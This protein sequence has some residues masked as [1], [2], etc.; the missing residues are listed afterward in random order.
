M[1]APSSASGYSRLNQRALSLAQP[2]SVLLELTYACNWRCVFCYNPR[3]FDRARLSA[4]EWEI[5]LDDL[6]LLGTLTVTLTGGEALT[7]PGFLDIARAVRSRAFALRIFTNGSLIDEAMSKEIAELE[8]LGVEMSLHGASAETHDKATAKPG[9]FGAMLAAVARLQR[10]RVR[11]VLKTPLTCLNESELDQILELVQ[12][13]GVSWRLD[14]TITP[15]DDGDKTPLDYRASPAGIERAMRLL[16][17]TGPSA[18]KRSPGEVNCGLGRTTLAID[19]EGN[20]FPCMQWRQS[21]LGNVREIRLKDLW[22]DSPAR[23]AAAEVARKAND[24]LVEIGGALSQFSYC[25]ALA[26]QSTGDA[27]TPDAGFVARARIAAR[28][29]QASA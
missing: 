23:S 21:S 27:L 29:R 7:H 14:P 4:S 6:R 8:P 25:P 17:P 20:V 18:L 5:V 12:E 3:H 24:K 28:L 15:R 9:S 16:H 26:Y 13:L 1:S 10:R 2:L 19:P 11:V 22:H